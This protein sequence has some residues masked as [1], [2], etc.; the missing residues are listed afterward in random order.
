MRT[1][2]FFKNMLL[3]SL[4]QVLTVIFN[5]AVR[6]VFIYTLSEA[7]LGINGLLASVLSVLN[8]ANLGIDAAVI[9]AMYKPVAEN[10]VEKTKSLLQFYRTAYRLIGCLILVLGFAVLTP[11]LPYLIKGSTD[12]V[13][14]RFVFWLYLLETASSYL[15]FAY[16]SGLLIANQKNYVISVVDY[17][18]QF[19]KAA[20]QIVLLLAL[21]RTPRTSF[22]VL[23]AVGLVFGVLRNLLIRRRV[24]QIYP[25]AR[26]LNAKPLS[27]EEKKG[28]Y[29][30]LVG[31]STNNICR[32]LNDGIDSAIVSA[33]IGLSA[34]GI[35]SNYLSIKTYVLQFLKI[36]FHPLTAGV[37]NLCAVES[38]EKKLD[39][40][41]SLQFTCFWIYGFCAI[42][43]WTLLDS[44]IVGVWLH[45]TRWL[46]PPAAVFL[47]SFN[48][49]IEGLARSVIVFRDANGLYWQTKY[50]Y[51][52]SSVFNAV[53]SVVLAG[54]MKLGVLGALLGTSASLVIMI[55]YDPVLVYRHVFR[56][57]AGE[58]YR[59]YFLELALVLLTGGLVAFLCRAFSAYT[60]GSFLART[61]I[62][63][64]VPN[65]LWY[66]MFRRD[67]R[68]NYLR[69]KVT[70]TL[71]LAGGK[72]KK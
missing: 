11:L 50:R 8:L 62:C 37:G 19:C 3:G 32:V 39:F 1:L 56:K 66:L 18:V 57:P 22:Y 58:Y 36:V 49:L 29:K 12:L 67:P 10:D 4:G 14:I 34:T 48:F 70:D 33:F 38:D 64:L 63:L 69:T 23:T 43:F 53:T 5:F 24:F 25:W 54:P 28:I 17:G 31:M 68:F 16:C 40:F 20:V 2:N 35:F 71:K 41:R 42:C 27:S 52:F 72:L 44:F 30:N 61:G 60:V 15:F 55:S 59:M 26:D 7:Y 6:T 51:I 65:G 46:L 21:R 13:D 47:I 9:Y 45:D